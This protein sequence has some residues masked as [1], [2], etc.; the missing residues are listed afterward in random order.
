MVGV[1]DRLALTHINAKAGKRASSALLAELN[2]NYL[3][4]LCDTR[5]RVPAFAASG[6][7]PERAHL[8]LG[9]TDGCICGES[10]R[11]PSTA[12]I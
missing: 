5:G 10:K 6:G 12:S 7:L 4:P 3:A 2:A 1:V 9:P 8:F 11:T